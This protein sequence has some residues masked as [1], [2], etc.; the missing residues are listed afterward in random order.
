MSPFGEG[1][2]F[3]MASKISS[4]PSPVLPEQEMAFVVSIPTTSSISFFVFSISDAG[5]SILFKIGIT[6]WFIS[7]AW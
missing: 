2:L 1:N 4:I 6:S 5:K 7:K 3:I